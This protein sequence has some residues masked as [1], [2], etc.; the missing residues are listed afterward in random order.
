MLVRIRSVLHLDKAGRTWEN[1]MM[2]ALTL[3]NTEEGSI[4]EKL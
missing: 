3:N 1:V 2:W 4:V